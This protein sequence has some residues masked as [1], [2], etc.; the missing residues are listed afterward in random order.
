MTQLTLLTTFLLILLTLLI[1]HSSHRI[2]TRRIFI[3]R[4]F[5]TPSKNLIRNLEI[6]RRYQNFSSHGRVNSKNFHHTR[7][8]SIP[9][10]KDQK[11]WKHPLRL[12]V[13]KIFRAVGQNFFRFCL[14][15]YFPKIKSFRTSKFAS[16]PV[17]ILSLTGCADLAVHGLLN[18]LREL[19]YLKIDFIAFAMRKFAFLTMVTSWIVLGRRISKLFTLI[20][21]SDDFLVI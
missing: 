20:Q 15:Q 12:F 2:S 3:S 9:R 10:E 11:F 4:T 21:L 8:M 17:S 13:C 16:H 19:S 18:E 5:P 14:W 7:H 1:S 6:F